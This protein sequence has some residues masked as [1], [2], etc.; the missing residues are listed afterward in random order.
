MEV[1][2]KIMTNF[3]MH[4]NCLLPEEGHL[5]NFVAQV[6]VGGGPSAHEL[7]LC[8]RMQQ[9][10]FIGNK[11]TLKPGKKLLYYKTHIGD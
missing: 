4:N 1:D 2:G 3:M 6:G 11:L 8:V 9:L 5:K 10:I 7:V